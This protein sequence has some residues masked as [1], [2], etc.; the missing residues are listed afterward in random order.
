M[1]AALD[2]LQSPARFSAGDLS[3]AHEIAVFCHI[4][5]VKLYKV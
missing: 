3:D 1:N 4:V 2:V 5:A